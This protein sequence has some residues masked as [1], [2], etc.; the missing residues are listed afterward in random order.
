MTNWRKQ[1]SDWAD[2]I[3]PRQGRMCLVVD[4][5]AA[6]PL[7]Q[8]LAAE[9]LAGPVLLLAADAGEADRLEQLCR[10]AAEMLGEGKPVIRVPAVG[11]TN[12]QYWIAGNDA[13]RCAA[14]QRA[15]DGEAGIYVCSVAGL[16]AP[17]FAP[18]VFRE[19]SFTVAPGDRAWTPET[20]S[21]HLVE[22]D[23]DNEF[24]VSRPGEFAR[25]GG[26]LDVYSP[27]HDAPVRL[28]FFGDVVES[29]RSFDAE[30]QRS[31][32][33]VESLRVVPRGTMASVPEEDTGFS[34]REYLPADVP[35]LAATPEHL[36]A[37][38]ERFGSEDSRQRLADKLESESLFAAIS[39]AVSAVGDAL[40]SALPERRVPAHAI[41]DL[42]PVLSSAL[43]ELSS[44][45]A[46][47][48]MLSQLRSWSAAG[49]LLVACC[50]S[51][52]EAARFREVAGS[53][54]D[55]RD[56]A[57]EVDP[58]SIPA[59]VALPDARLI[60]LSERELFGRRPQPAS[61]RRSRKPLIEEWRESEA[62]ELEEGCYAVHATRGI[63]RYHGVREVETAGQLQEAAELEFADEMRL[64]VPLDQIH[65]VS[66]YYGG[67]K[68]AP[69]LAKIGGAA[70]RRA[71]GAAE[72]A[73]WDMAAEMLRMDALRRNSRGLS[74][75]RGGDWELSFAQS[76]PYRE[77]PDQERAIAEVLEDMEAER[78]MDRLL[79]GDVGYGKTEVAV[80]AAFR[81]VL[82]GKQVAVLVPTTVLAQQHYTTFVNRMADYPVA[83]GVLSR[84]QT[85]AE[86]RRT[87]EQLAEGTL[88][89]V[90]GTHR[91]VQSDVMFNDLGLLIVDEEQRFGVKHKEKLKRLRTTLDILTMTATPIPRTLYFSIS[92]I[93]HLST[94]M[95]PPAD[96]RPVTTVVGKYDET[97]I[98][99]AILRELEREGQVFFVHNRVRT[100]WRMAEHLRGL[101]PEAR[102]SVAHGQMDAHELAETMQS[103]VNGEV[104][105]LVCTTIVESG[106][107]IP[108][109]NTIL[110]DRADRFGLAELYQLRG[111]VGRY[112]HQAYAYFLL[113]PM[114]ALP[115][116]ARE[117]LAAIRRYTDL[118]TGFKLALRDLE[119]R[120]AGNLLGNEQSGHIAAVGFELY[121]DLLRRAVDQLE[122]GGANVYPQDVDLD[123]EQV[124]FAVE[125]RRGRLAAAIPADYVADEAVRLDCY[126]ELRRLDSVSRIDAFGAELR[127][128]F[129]PPPAQVSH[130]LATARIRVSAAARGI[131]SVS[132]RNSRLALQTDG[133]LLK[134]PGG[135]L[136]VLQTDTAEQQ[137]E[138]IEETLRN[139][140]LK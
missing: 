120:G 42:L 64:Y 22:L 21:R 62:S 125:D 137:L 127:D 80:R 44:D 27:V 72:Q 77:T 61:R 79:C 69:P 132:C 99:E 26:I 11:G 9:V 60:L 96:R 106:V 124:V 25:R 83:I 129:G 28:E 123:L 48:Q 4:D 88:D 57:L 16:Q 31:T 126:R 89:I 81:A 115:E 70:W 100:I 85:G 113:P 46:R 8:V 24:E 114:G 102:F 38:E 112:H 59:G 73:V 29:M 118:G 103:Y 111:R 6:V 136:P 90:V 51:E 107:D 105:V 119:I 52:G 87:L 54:A 43:G 39:D 95:T 68:T 17:A 92:G 33:A 3:A 10:G 121:C 37:H 74:L 14:M 116:N 131:H 133:G 7:V 101:V 104:D 30:T 58:V 20:L 134:K 94:I 49:Y 117:R 109:A 2:A 130:L 93:R 65:L 75:P 67:G 47:E 53:A 82:H 122:H 139:A 63:C 71:R 13:V 110:I 91:L 78:P 1:L 76:F 97:L 41:A 34:F 55:L 40:C 66:R 23:Y 15:L 50:G 128:R 98:R 140:E 18:E 138:E 12:R 86:Q 84:F 35:V 5:D 32:G 45:D 56:L 19:R 135:G 36:L 108:N